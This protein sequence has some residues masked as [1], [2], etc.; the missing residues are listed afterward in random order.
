LDWNTRINSNLLSRVLFGRKPILLLRNGIFL[1]R[2]KNFERKKFYG[3]AEL[4]LVFLGRPTSWKGVN[5]ILD[6]AQS[7]ALSDAKILFFF[8]YKPD[9]LFDNLPTDVSGR[10][11]VVVGKSFRDYEPNFGDV[12]LYPAN[13]GV[14]ARF[15]ESISLNCLEMASVG[16]PSI[17]T[18]SGLLTWPEFLHNPLFVE[19]DWSDN[20]ETVQK[21]CESHT[22][23]VTDSELSR[24]RTII[25]VENHTSQLLDFLI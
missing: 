10:I 24:I 6:L 21:I 11:S 16:I 15:I 14:S 13:Y 4:R 12:H 17:L 5:S 1:D 20:I 19:V 2:I 25:S 9:G 3:D 8:P 18:K 22:T 23:Q 7:Q